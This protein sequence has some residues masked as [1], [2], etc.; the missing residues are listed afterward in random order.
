MSFNPE[1]TK[2]AQEVVF[3]RKSQKVTHPTVYFNNSPVTQSSSKK[4]LGIHLDEKLNFIHHI[5]EKIS[6]ANKGTGVIKKLNNTLPRKALL[7]LY[8]SFVRP[9]LDH[10]E[11][12]QMKY[13]FLLQV[14]FG[15]INSTLYLHVKK[16]TIACNTCLERILVRLNLV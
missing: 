11:S 3:S 9:H 12:T 10:G 14:Y 15:L 16:L 8:K 1:I 2:Q 7:T 6:K 13:L 5:K 4:H